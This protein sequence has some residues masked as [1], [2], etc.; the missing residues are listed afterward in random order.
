MRMG[1]IDRVELEDLLFEG[2]SLCVPKLLVRERSQGFDDDEWRRR[3]RPLERAVPR[4]PK[5]G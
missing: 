2:W 5:R 3:A 1:V 4:G